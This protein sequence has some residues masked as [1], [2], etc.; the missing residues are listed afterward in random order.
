M[1]SFGFTLGMNFALKYFLHSYNAR[2]PFG[3]VCQS[4]LLKNWVSLVSPDPI[5]G[6]LSDEV[7]QLVDV[8]VWKNIRSLY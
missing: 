5:L 3:R 6:V 1:T 7:I 8:E 2:A 4:T